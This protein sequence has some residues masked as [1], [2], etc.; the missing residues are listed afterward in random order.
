MKSNFDLPK[1]LSDLPQFEFTR[2]NP[3]SRS[4]SA[5]EDVAFGI[6]SQSDLVREVRRRFKAEGSSVSKAIT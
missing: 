2:A 4:Q 6:T 1:S 3:G 5:R